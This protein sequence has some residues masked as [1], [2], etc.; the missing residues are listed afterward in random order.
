M[1]VIADSGEPSFE[2][3]PEEEPELLSAIE[4]VE[5]GEVIGAAELLSRLHR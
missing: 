1:T 5:R 2:A 3:T 4:E